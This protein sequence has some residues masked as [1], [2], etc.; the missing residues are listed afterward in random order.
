MDPLPISASNVSLPQLAGSVAQY[1]CEVKNADETILKLLNEVGS[2][3]DLHLTLNDGIEGD[4]YSSGPRLVDLQALEKLG[5]AI[6]QTRSALQNLEW[7]LTPILKSRIARKLI[8]PF[9]KEE[10]WQLVNAIERQKGYFILALSAVHL[11]NA[12][13]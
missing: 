12:V 11:L 10:T 9:H 13:F 7:K 8:W 3:R 1:I 6:E 5:G 2:I 4:Q